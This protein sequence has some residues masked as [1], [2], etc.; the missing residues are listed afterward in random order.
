MMLEAGALRGGVV[1]DAR[2]W[3][4]DDEG[5]TVSGTL[6][7]CII[8]ADSMLEGPHDTTC[9]LDT[10]LIHGRGGPANL[11]LSSCTGVEGLRT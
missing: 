6:P 7:P 8:T 4:D 5:V 2:A 3:D 1:E 11:T 10:Q 9:E